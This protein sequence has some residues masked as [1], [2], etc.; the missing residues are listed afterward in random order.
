MSLRHVVPPALAALL[1]A[2]PAPAR[3]TIG[4]WTYDKGATKLTLT[5]VFE[6][7]P[8]TGYQPLQV[9]MTNGTAD[10]REWSLS[11]RSSHGEKSTE[12]TFDVAIEAGKATTPMVLVPLSNAYDTGTYRWSGGYHQLTIKAS[13]GQLVPNDGATNDQRATEMPAIAI[14]DRLAQKS[15][16]QLNDEARKAFGTSGYANAIFG[17][18][19][20]PGMLPEVWLGFSGFDYV[21]IADDEW[22]K[23]SP[24]ARAALFQWVR[25]GGQLH[26][27]RSSDSV[28][29]ASLGLK[30]GNASTTSL[31]HG[32]GAVELKSWGGNTFDAPSVVAA[33][34]TG[35]NLRGHLSDS[36]H[37]SS[38][39]LASDLGERNFAG[40]Q[41]VVFLLLFGVLVGPINLFV[42][43]PAGKRHKLFFTTPVIATGASL[44][45]IG[46]ILVQDGTGGRGR[47]FM[48]VEIVPEDAMAY[49]TQEQISRTGVLFRPPSSC[50]P[51]PSATNSSSARRPGPNSMTVA[52]VRG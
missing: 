46:L 10:R 29:L 26:L 38:W 11:C 45:L 52:T 33:Y 51:P 36:Y 23:L 13:S 31:K 2:G 17:S 34:R 14:S 5:G 16:T 32:L 28:T 47:R 9:E 12:S 6:P 43:A 49:V 39:K 48:A 24:G 27:F 20:D 42:L 44:I 21:L 8:P 7:P 22:L 30:A 4:A 40:W 50:H 18:R 3:Q 25:F 41:V 35:T 15:L 19:F 1:W 37:G